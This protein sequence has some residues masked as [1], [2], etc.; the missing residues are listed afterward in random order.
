L[1]SWFE[2]NLRCG[3]GAAPLASTCCSKEGG[4]PTENYE[5]KDL[6]QPDEVHTFDKGRL[7]QV[8]VGGTTVQR[9][10]LEPGWRS[11][12]SREPP[13]LA[14]WY[15]TPHLLYHAA[16]QIRI[17]TASGE[18][19]Q[20]GPGEVVSLPPGFGAYVV[21]DDPVVIVGLRGPLAGRDER[22]SGERQI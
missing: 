9:L 22:G 15:D 1:P 17:V 11:A 13:A 12:D 20:A 8:H 14:E 16:G 6:N 18:Q 2:K 3:S 19:I 7:E 21:G 4:I 10:V 5:R